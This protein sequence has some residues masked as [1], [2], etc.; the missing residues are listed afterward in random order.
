MLWL[1]NGLREIPR[2]KLKSIVEDI[3]IPYL[4]SWTA[5][6]LIDPIEHLDAGHAGTYGGR[7]G[8]L[9]LQSC[10]LLITLEQD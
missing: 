6:D 3:G 9:I 2:E 7:S 10:D 4:T 8:N 5:A 1:G